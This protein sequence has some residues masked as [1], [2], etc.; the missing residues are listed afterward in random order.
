MSFFFI[1]FFYIISILFNFS[2]CEDSD[3]NCNEFIEYF[4][5]KE[6][7]LAKYISNKIH[8]LKNKSQQCIDILVK[9][10]KLLA[11]DFYL[12][13][14]GKRGVSYRENL[15]MSINTLKKALDD[16]H[17]K[18]RFDQIQ[19]QTVFPAFQWAQSLNEIFLE[20]KFAHRHD[21]PGCLEIKDLSVK[22]GSNSVDLIG[23]CVLGDVPIKIDFHIKT[24][25]EIS[26]ENS[27]HGFG[28]VG[29][30]QITLKKKEAGKYWNRL[31]P[32]G[33]S[34]PN[35][36]RVWFEMKEKFEESLKEFEKDDDDEEFN[37]EIEEIKKKKA[38]G[39]KKNKEKKHH[40]KDADL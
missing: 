29:R 17:N 32:D 7:D 25:A 15:E 30:Y 34:I 20:I 19:Y 27:T 40:K 8:K 9:N 31:L 21:S 16:I 4:S 3:E 18:H 2:F 36:M 37:K 10:G 28:S 13:E 35:N 14:L 12:T 11:L 39:K 38:E 26:K 1:I 33:Q 5:E 24:W 22:F 6:E 23:Y